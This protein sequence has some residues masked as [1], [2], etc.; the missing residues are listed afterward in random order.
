MADND[1]AGEL[2]D[3]AALAANAAGTPERVDPEP[4]ARCLG[5]PLDGRSQQLHQ[6]EEG[7]VLTHVYLHGGP[8]IESR[9]VLGRD[10]T[11]DWAY[12]LM[13]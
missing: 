2:G 8:K 6:P 13:D 7:Q 11:G 4:S 1:I 5:G 3:W 10:D 9:Y 12:F